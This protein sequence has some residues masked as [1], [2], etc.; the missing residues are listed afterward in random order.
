MSMVGHEPGAA[1]AARFET[2]VRAALDLTAEHDLD[3]L[4]QRMVERAAEVAQARYAAL[5]VFDERGRIER[6]VH[7][8]ISAAEV[9]AIGAL[10]EGRGLLGEVVAASGPIRIPDLTADPRSVGFP[11]GH[12][13]MRSF[14][15]VPVR[16]GSR[17]FG[18][19]YLTE[20]TGGGDFDAEDEQLVATL[21]TFA[22]AAIEGAMLLSAERAQAAAEERAHARDQML[23]QVI[24]AQEAE[25]ARI[26]R[27]LHDQ[28]GQALT[29]VLLALR[30][31]TD[32]LDDQP[33]DTAGARTRA[34]EVRVLVA[35]ALQ[36][37]RQL[38][39]EL[40]PTVLDDVGLVPAVRR[41]AADQLGRHDI[42]VDVALD[43]L[44]DDTRFPREV[45]TVVY[46]VVQEALTNV[47][48]HARAASAQVT[49]SAA[50]GCVRARVADDGAGFEPPAGRPR[51]LGLAGMAERAGLVGG[52]VRIDSAPGRGTVV[53]LEVPVV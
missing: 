38:A 15:G 17:R 12:P 11:P 3:H 43:G 18:N 39:F 47:V 50:P 1:S 45:E 9:A 4:L 28:V 41:L 51:S 26:A 8:G 29:S 23:A 33:P 34:D 25:R 27:D 30:L 36:D 6:F 46:R 37:V 49:L 14:L 13:P 53:A 44:D 52:V 40:R 5:G 31:V 7:H 42:T 21:A 24:G 10:P 22:A 20:K 32:A 35:D 16:L 19:L 48:R 2:L